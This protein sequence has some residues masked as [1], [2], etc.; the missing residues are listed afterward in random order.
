MF[1]SDGPLDTAQRTQDT[2][3]SVNR[4]VASGGNNQLP[5]EDK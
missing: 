5:N 4:S 1:P 3:I 2:S